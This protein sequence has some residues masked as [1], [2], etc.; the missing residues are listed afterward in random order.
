MYTIG[1]ENI[2]ILI[3]NVQNSPHTYL[4]AYPP[5]KKEKREKIKIKKKKGGKMMK[6][7]CIGHIIDGRI[8]DIRD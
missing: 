8:D 5:K 3:D 1:Y 6:I 2:W 7:K 4:I